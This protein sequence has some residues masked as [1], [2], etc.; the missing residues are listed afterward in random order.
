LFSL[1]DT[2]HGGSGQTTFAL[3]DLLG[4][5]PVGVGAGATVAIWEQGEKKC[6]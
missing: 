2:K 6:N 3:P 4:A 5:V 1:L